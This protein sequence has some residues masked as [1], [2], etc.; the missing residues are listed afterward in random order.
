[1]WTAFQI[2]PNTT[3]GAHYFQAGARPKAGVTLGQQSWIRT[4]DIGHH[5]VLDISVEGL[6]PNEVRA[7]ARR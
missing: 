4:L 3:D 1:M 6:A 7:A 5:E 2:D